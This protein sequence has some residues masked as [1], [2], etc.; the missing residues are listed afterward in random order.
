[1]N[2]EHNVSD[3]PDVDVPEWDVAL[4]ALATEECQKLGRP[5]T[6]DD[7]SRLAK[8]YA[9]R[10]NDI[11]STVFELCFHGEWCYLDADGEERVLAREEVEALFEGG[12]IREEDMHVLPGAWRPKY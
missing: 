1:M 2:Q 11:M 7:F 4:E 12:R 5:L 9:I 10:F 8:E 6:T 3:M